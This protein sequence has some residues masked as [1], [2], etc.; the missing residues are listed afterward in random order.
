[1]TLV[2]EFVP[3]WTS[4]PGATIQDL[5]KSKNISSSDVAR[6]CGL[7]RSAFNALLQGSAPLTEKIAQSLAN[8]LGGSVSFWIRREARFQE[9]TLIVEADQWVQSL[10]LTSMKKLNWLEVPRDWRTR[11]DACLDFFGL[12]TLEGWKRN[13]AAPLQGVRFRTSPTYTNQVASVS[14]WLRAGEIAHKGFSGGS[15]DPDALLAGIDE[16]RELSRVADPAIFFPKLQS[17]AANCGVSCVLVP[18]PEGCAASGASRL[19]PDGSAII[20]LSGRYLSDD[21]F[22][23]SYFHEIGHLIL[24]ADKP[25]HIDGDP[26]A[27]ELDSS[28]YEAN[29]FSAD[30]LWP[31]EDRPT[32][33]SE[34][35]PSKRDVL[36]LASA[37]GTSPGIITGQLQSSGILEYADYN[38]FKRRYKR[39][40]PKLVLKR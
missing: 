19:L 4:S 31:L 34:K 18:A 33:L 2:E 15:F 16:M 11:I 17:L 39:E 37:A 22:W 3:R 21:Q 28:E 32:K 10:P 8:Y 6:A 24:H 36:R 1:M 9:S 13:Y 20:Q 30:V 25:L 38:Y 27:I 5:I 7:D 14:S 23:F 40:G 29:T 26:A 35:K 12:D